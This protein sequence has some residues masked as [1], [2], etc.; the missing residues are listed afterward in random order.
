MKLEDYINILQGRLE[1][2]GNV[3][4]AITESGYYSEGKFADL[5]EIPEMKSIQI[6]NE[7]KWVDGDYKRVDPIYQDFLVLGHSHQSY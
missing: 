7:Y 5:Y 6:N 4:V 2:V 1:L 3:D